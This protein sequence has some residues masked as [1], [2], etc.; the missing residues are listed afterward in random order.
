MDGRMLESYLNNKQRY[1]YDKSLQKMHTCLVITILPTIQSHKI[2][3]HHVRNS[4][5]IIVKRIRP[6]NELQNAV[7]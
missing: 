4:M 5:Y 1:V 2:H 7:K 3:K 6:L